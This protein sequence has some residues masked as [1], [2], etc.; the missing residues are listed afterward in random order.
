MQKKVNFQDRDFFQTPFSRAEIEGLLK[1]RKAEEMFSFRS[2]SFK[3]LGLARD[4]LS[5]N[6]LIDLMLQEPRLIRRPVVKIGKA[7]Y[8]G[9]DSKM[10][11][12]LL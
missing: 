5:E 6:E 3:A 10:L 4:S 1:G 11:E 7:V 2:P 8:F 9:A 12:E